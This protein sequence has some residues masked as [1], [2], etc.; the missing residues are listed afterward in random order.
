MQ[1]HLA[2][3]ITPG[4]DAACPI[5]DV[6]WPLQQKA[7]FGGRGYF[8]PRSE[9]H[10]VIVTSTGNAVLCVSV[11]GVNGRMRTIGPRQDKPVKVAV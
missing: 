10:Y 4:W 6:L 2:V 7:A 8:G 9:V 11:G 3:Q 5:L 1:L